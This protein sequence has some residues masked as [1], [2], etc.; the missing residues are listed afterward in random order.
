MACIRGG[1]D[2]VK[3]LVESGADINKVDDDG[4]TPLYRACVNGDLNIVKYLVGMKADVNL[5]A[6]DDTT[7]LIYSCKKNNIKMAQ[8]LIENGADV[9]CKDYNGRTPLYIACKRKNLDLVKSLV[10]HGANLNIENEAGRNPLYRALVSKDP[11]ICIY[12]IKN[13]AY[14]KKFE[15][16]KV[17]GSTNLQKQ[18]WNGNLEEVE[19]LLDEG[20]NIDERDR[21]GHNVLDYAC[22]KHDANMVNLLIDRG[23]K[24]DIK[25]CFPILQAAA[26]NENMNMLDKYIKFFRDKAKREDKI[27]SLRECLM[28][29]KNIYKKYDSKFDKKIKNFV[30][31]LTNIYVAKVNKKII[32]PKIEHNM[33]RGM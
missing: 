29:A 4:Y 23:I 26:D 14:E 19:K 17:F 28:L 9:D 2:I 27:G 18:C 16:Q 24:I 12:L 22:W 1:L 31:E 15:I 6:D 30:E 21:E 33:G 8:Y 20:A 7:A 3:H 25:Y 5:K 11:D 32:P 13:G 10:E